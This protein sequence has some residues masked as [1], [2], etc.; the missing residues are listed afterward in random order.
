[1]TS[2]GKYQNNTHPQSYM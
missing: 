2:Q 1:M